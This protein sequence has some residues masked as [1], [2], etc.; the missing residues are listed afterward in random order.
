VQSVATAE[1]VKPE[2]ATPNDQLEELV[3]TDLEEL[4][5]T[6]QMPVRHASS[7][8][9]SAPPPLPIEAR[10][11]SVPP[12]PPQSGMFRIK[13]AE[14]RPPSVDP[15]ELA[16][17]VQRLQSELHER[18]T[19]V[20]RM[21]LAV[22]LR[23]DRVHDLE[24]ALTHQRERV[25]EL[26]RSLAAQQTHVKALEDAL[27]VNQATMQDDLRRIAGVG[28]VFARKLAERG[29]TRFAQLASFGP[30]QVAELADALGIPVRRIESA[31]W[32]AKAA[33]LAAQSPSSA[34]AD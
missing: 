27:R 24:R 1:N 7:E 4:E 15:A 14:S 20:D 6:L 5:P 34:I 9:S 11:S 3:D 31:G 32:V 25:Q 18:T 21:R 30:E 8:R 19:Q 29:V 2:D 10:R 28:P 12:S 16:Q 22:T 13:G 26:E 33:E 23:D 17:Q